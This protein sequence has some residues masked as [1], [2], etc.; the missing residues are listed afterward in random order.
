MITFTQGGSP[1]YQTNKDKEAVLEMFKT[2]GRYVGGYT[3]GS[4]LHMALQIC[5]RVPVDN[6]PRPL[7]EIL[8]E[9][10]A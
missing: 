10:E 4:P 3:N 9:S 5:E 7:H 8:N 6:S 2:L 1:F